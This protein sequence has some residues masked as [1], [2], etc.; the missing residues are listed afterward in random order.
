MPTLKSVCSTGGRLQM[1]KIS[2][3]SVEKLKKLWALEDLSIRPQSPTQPKTCSGH[4]H[5]RA[6]NWCQK[7]APGQR[8]I[9][10]HCLNFS[11]PWVPSNSP[12]KGFPHNFHALIWATCSLKEFCANDWEVLLGTAHHFAIGSGAFRVGFSQTLRA[13]AGG[14]WNLRMHGSQLLLWA[15]SQFFSKMLTYKRA[16]S[17][18]KIFIVRARP[19]PQLW[20]FLFSHR[21]QGK[22]DRG[23]TR[24]LRLWSL[25]DFARV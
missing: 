14:L 12:W 21:A 15:A 16:Y 24:F 8:F 22:W 19:G 23:C 13:S 3:R 6:Q 5:G 11:V 18:V 4:F 7:L 1:V 2:K 10:R 17:G 25:L 9:V 20:Y